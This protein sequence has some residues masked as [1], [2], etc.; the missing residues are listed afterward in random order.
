M[1]QFGPDMVQFGPDMVQFGPDM[2]Q[3]G[4][5]MVQFGPDMVPSAWD[6]LEEFSIF[7]FY[8][9]KSPISNT[10]GGT[11]SISNFSHSGHGSG[12]EPITVCPF[13]N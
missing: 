9:A 3:F 7:E 6:S 2:V 11:L 5:D 12:G 10:G 1:V 4:P 13:P 8:N